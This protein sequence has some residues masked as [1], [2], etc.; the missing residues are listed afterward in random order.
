MAISQSNLLVR[1]II[2]EFKEDLKPETETRIVKWTSVG[3]KLLALGFV[4]ALE[5]SDTYA[6]ALRLLGDIFIA[7]TLHATLLGMY[8][9]SLDKNGPLA[10]WFV[11]MASGIYLIL[12]ANKF[13]AL[14]TSLGN[15][16]SDCSMWP[17]YHC[18]SN[19]LSCMYGHT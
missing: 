7:Q 16:L 4:F 13:G 10:W 14:S 8:Q 15:T 6:I 5:S 2:K 17:P 19:C 12:V 11:G 1:N 9:K 3:F 18:L